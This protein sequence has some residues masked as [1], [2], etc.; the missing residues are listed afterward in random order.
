MGELHTAIYQHAA[1]P[2]LVPASVRIDRLEAVVRDH[3]GPLDLVVCPELFLSGYD[4]GSLVHDRAEAADGPSAA[5][6]SEIAQR[7][8]TAIV[9]GYPESDGD[10]LYNAA[11]VYGA[12]GGHLLNYRKRLIPPGFEGTYFA[13]GDSQGVFE[14]NGWKLAVLICYDVEFPEYVR[15]AALSGADAIVAPTALRNMW[16]FVADTMLPTRAFENGV[17]VLYANHAGAEGNCEYLGRSV[18]VG[19]SGEEAARAGDSEELIAATL[20]RSAVLAARATLPY[21]DVVRN[22]L[23]G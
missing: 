12:D 1:T 13:Q 9:V 19:P 3:D 14:I 2:D 17:Y 18:I 4:I 8:G 7:Y 6:V 23:P 11:M 21:L 16:G 15:Q 22:G 20:D 10:T 5:R